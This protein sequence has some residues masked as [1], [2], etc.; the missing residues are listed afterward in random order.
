MKTSSISSLF[1]VALFMLIACFTPSCK[2]SDS[3][4]SNAVPNKLAITEGEFAG[5]DHTYSPNMGFWSIASGT[6]RYVH[7][8]LG[9]NSN[10]VG[11]SPE[12]MD[13]LFYSGSTGSIHFPSQDG[14]FIHF[15]LTFQG[16]V[17][18]FGEDNADL[19]ITDL[20]DNHFR[21]ILT[22]TF[23]DISDDSRKITISLLIDM[24]L[25]MI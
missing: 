12:L 3:K 17:Y 6:V 20:T 15:G 21:G 10:Q 18:Y 14:Q 23:S 16:V 5:Y 7:L 4:S 13:I 2:K 1:I 9:D 11:S 22:G 25:Q 8:V 19:V 24:E